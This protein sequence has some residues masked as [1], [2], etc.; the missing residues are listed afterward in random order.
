MLSGQLLDHLVRISQLLGPDIVFF[1][2][3]SDEL[4]LHIPQPAQLIKKPVIDF[5]DGVDL[6]GRHA[7]LQRLKHHEQPVVV[8][9]VQ[10]V[11]Y[12]LIG[13]FPEGGAV[14]A[15]MADFRPPHRLHKR[16]L[17]GLTNGHDLAGGLHLGAQGA[18]GVHKLVK[19]P[20]GHLHHHIIQRRFEAG[21][22]GARHRVADLPQGV[23][24]G[25]LGRHLGNGVA[26]G[27]GGQ[28]GGAGHPGV[29]L[30]NRIFEAVGMQGE[31]AVAAPFHPQGG[32]DVQ[33]SGTQH[34][35]FLVRKGHSRRDD[36]AV[37]CVHA[38]RVEV[39]HA[40]HGDDVARAVPHDFKFDFLPSGD[41]LFHQDLMN[42]RQTEAVC[43]NFVQLF[44]CFG[45]AAAAAAQCEGGA[46]DD[47][48]A[49]VG[50]EIHG[51]LQVGHH[52]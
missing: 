51:R 43:R 30:D 32:D 46:H 19:G 52:L 8:A 39:F 47:R 2:Q 33:R 29:D 41:A 24:Y 36:N 7:P 27:L 34:L 45:N 28:G 5:G 3:P 25:D 18:L 16:L 15:G 1:R 44:H 26:G 4:P 35:V 48:I 50:G 12:L 10:F 23:A 14:Q 31:L 42:R 13:Q 37:A 6:L 49:D 38:D 11:A 17:K 9:V 21:V 20:L 22:G 40:A